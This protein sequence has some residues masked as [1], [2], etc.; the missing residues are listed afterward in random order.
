MIKVIEF[1]EHRKIYVYIWPELIRFDGRLFLLLFLMFVDYFV[2][3]FNDWGTIVSGI[4][5]DI[6]FSV[7][8]NSLSQ[9][10]FR[11]NARSI[12]TLDCSLLS[13]LMRKNYRKCI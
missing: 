2:M 11:L 5:I 3:D 4:I 1:I 12:R 10:N 9:I 6:F 7:F 13:P 8:L